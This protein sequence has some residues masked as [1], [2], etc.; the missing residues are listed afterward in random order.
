MA[1]WVDLNGDLGE[2]FGVYS[3]GQDEA[4][5]ELITSAN[6]ACGFHGGDPRVMERTVRRA[7]ERGVAV[8]A[9]V[10]YPDLV[11]FGR[12]RLDA[13]PEEVRTDVLYQLGALYAFCRA[14][15]VPLQHVKPHGALYHDAA[16]NRSLA[17]AIAAA[18]AAFDPDLILVA[19][20]GSQL[21][22]AGQ[23]A[24][25][26]V[27]YEGFVDRHYNPDGTLV[28]R[29]HPEAVILDPQVAGLRALRLVREGKVR[30]LGG[31]DL[32]LTVHTLCIHGD[33][34]AAVELA[35]AVRRHL[36]EGGIRLAPLR[37][38]L[39]ARQDG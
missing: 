31:E 27:A 21:A 26:R 16:A 34:P 4:M 23:A 9:H 22:A 17:D 6:V 29:R 8:G 25:L 39:A 28:S 24:G 15:G 38:V 32:A 2:S 20:P 14:C 36:E 18:V 11:G 1:L 19:P 10:S 37:Q 5:L 3:L 33:N 7:A 13:T 35:R 12:R 30:A